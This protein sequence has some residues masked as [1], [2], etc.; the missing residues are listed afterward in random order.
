MEG[1][2]QANTLL[3]RAEKMALNLVVPW[4]CAII[5]KNENLAHTKMGGSRS[6]IDPEF[7]HDLRICLSPTSF[8]WTENKQTIHNLKTLRTCSQICLYA[9]I[10]ID[11]S[12]WRFTF[13]PQ[14]RPESVS[15][16]TTDK[17][18]LT[19]PSHGGNFITKTSNLLEKSQKST[20][21]GFACTE[22]FF[23]AL[24]RHF[25]P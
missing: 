25:L 12:Y 20:F 4:H 7:V 6:F 10:Y 8:E 19:S 22:K 3:T 5:I 11:N 16:C 9:W 17:L 1:K 2:T 18:V 13:E 24:I 14:R 21:N 23:N 15:E